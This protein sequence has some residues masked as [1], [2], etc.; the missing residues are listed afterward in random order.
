MKL[1]MHLVLTDPDSF[2]RGRYDYC[3]HLYTEDPNVSG[4]VHCGTVDLDVNVDRGPLIKATVDAINHEI[5]KVRDDC[6]AQ[7]D[8]LQR[9]K[10]E[11]LAITHQ[12]ESDH[13]KP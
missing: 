7:L 8:V 12:P 10:D 13:A 1:K 5:E 11:L 2:L 4:W 6:A 9:R 3:F